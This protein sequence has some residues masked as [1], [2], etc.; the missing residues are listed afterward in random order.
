MGL[1]VPAVG[2][3]RRHIVVRRGD[4]A[5][6][7]V[8]GTGLLQPFSFQGLCGRAGGAKGTDAQRAGN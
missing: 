3:V 5:Q 6:H 2:G 1:I 4:S 8:H 7:N